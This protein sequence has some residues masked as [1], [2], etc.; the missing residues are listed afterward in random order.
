M[1][2]AF[3]HSFAALALGKTLTGGKMPARFW[4]L[5]VA[6]AVLPDIDII[7]FYF[8]VHY[9]SIFGHR[10]FTHSLAFA[11][12]TGIVATF[13]TFPA[14]PG[15][16]KKRW[17]LFLFFFAVT[18]FHGVLDAMTNGGYGIGFFIPFDDARYFL[19]WR[20]M[21]VSS[22][23]IAE[24][25]TRR[26]LTILLNE[27]LWI[28]VPLILLTILSTVIRHKLRTGKNRPFARPL[29]NKRGK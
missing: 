27:V 10:G 3:T 7:G 22:I 19:P 20:I 2:T 21:E 17:T 16:S 11:A 29:R 12:L 15:L 13:L 4:L 23:R 25:F 28:W 18:A 1:P 26:S 6:C 5:A 24:F 9:A 8:G 14:V